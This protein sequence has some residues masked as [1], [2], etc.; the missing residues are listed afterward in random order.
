MEKHIPSRMCV[1]CRTRKEKKELIKVVKVGEDFVV[2]GDDKTFGRGAYV[3]KE[4]ACLEKAV[5]KRAFDKSFKIKLP[6]GVYEALN[7]LRSR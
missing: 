6:D 4:G 5:K 7:N 1:V 2:D 3:C